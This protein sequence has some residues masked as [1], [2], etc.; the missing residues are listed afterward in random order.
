MQGLG[1]NAYLDGH[2]FYKDAIRTHWRVATDYVWNQE[3]RAKTFLDNAYN[4]L[5]DKGGP[6][7][8]NF[9]TMEGAWPGRVVAVGPGGHHPW[10]CYGL[11]GA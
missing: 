9:F 11:S 10:S 2:A 7:Q 1:Y 4:F 5:Q 6:S 3:P 8:A